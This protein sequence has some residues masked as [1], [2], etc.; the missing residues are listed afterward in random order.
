MAEK[1]RIESESG[2]ERE[3]FGP[4]AHWDILMFV[5]LLL[6]GTTAMQVWTLYQEPGDRPTRFYLFLFALALYVFTFFWMARVS[7]LVRKVPLIRVS[8][9]GLGLRSPA[10][11]T[12]RVRPWREVAAI[13]HENDDELG[14]RLTPSEDG[15]ADVIAVPLALRGASKADVRRAI[16]SW[17]GAE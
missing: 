1:Q 16:E 15:I 10:A 12:F 4:R 11:E 9:E 8:S 14:V 7:R 3:F 13:E 2:Q 17:L 6:V 5:N